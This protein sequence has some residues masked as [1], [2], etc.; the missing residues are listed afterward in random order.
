MGCA[1]P[2]LSLLPLRPCTAVSS[3]DGVYSSQIPIRADKLR[4]V[5]TIVCNL[6]CLQLNVIDPLVEGT[7][8][9]R[10]RCIIH[11]ARCTMHDACCNAGAKENVVACFSCLNTPSRTIRI[12]QK[13][14]IIRAFVE[15]LLFRH[16][17][18]LDIMCSKID[19]I[20]LW[21]LGLYNKKY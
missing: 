10:L 5:L 18:F 14:F 9:G 16:L 3:R 1:A 19:I 11:N 20:I 4:F 6:W 17:I 12:A 8:M 7:T 13:I 2:L 15:L 21:R